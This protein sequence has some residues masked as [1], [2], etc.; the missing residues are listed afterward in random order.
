MYGATPDNAHMDACGKKS[1][2]AC[3]FYEIICG[4][5]PNEQ[6]ECQ[7][8]HCFKRLEMQDELKTYAHSRSTQS[9]IRRIYWLE[10]GIV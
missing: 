10:H 4:K 1:E 7:I 2:I 9:I 8:W 6:E 5:Y 3:R